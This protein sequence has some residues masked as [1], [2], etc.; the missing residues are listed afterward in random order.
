LTRLLQ[1]NNFL[2][3][4]DNY[5]AEGKKV[6]PVDALSSAYRKFLNQDSS[7]SVQT[8]SYKGGK[9]KG[10]GGKPRASEGKLKA[11]WLTQEATS[12]DLLMLMHPD[13]VNREDGTYLL[14]GSSNDGTKVLVTGENWDSLQFNTKSMNPEY[15]PSSYLEPVPTDPVNKD[16]SRR[17]LA[18]DLKS[19]PRST[20]T[21]TLKDFRELL[22][23][24][25]YSKNKKISAETY[26]AL[27]LGLSTEALDAADKATAPKRIVCQVHPVR[28]HGV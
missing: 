3:E 16:L 27:S 9:S 19:F 20:I 26:R 21:G 6:L 24:S 1:K 13:L 28:A 22:H 5:L 10:K 4:E 2:P 14:E 12:F 7:L 23:C 25:V 18:N 17:S 11:K 15:F 8:I